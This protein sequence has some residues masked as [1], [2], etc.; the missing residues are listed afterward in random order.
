MLSQIYFTDDVI[1]WWTNGNDIAN[2]GIWIWPIDG[3]EFSGGSSSQFK[4]W[5]PGSEFLSLGIIGIK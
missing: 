5:G 3:V 2:E 4:D 1:N